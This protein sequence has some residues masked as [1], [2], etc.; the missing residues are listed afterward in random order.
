VKFTTSILIL[1]YIFFALPAKSQENW[2]LRKDK[3]G[4]KVYSRATTN[5]KFDELKVE[6]EVDGTISQL[7]AL[8][9]D[10]NTQYE[11]AYKTKK[12][13]L[14]KKVNDA[15]V[16]FYTEIECP[17]PYDNRDMVV[18]MTMQQNPANKVL[19]VQ[20]KNVD[21]YLPLKKGIV[22]LKYS[23]AV[24]TV[25]PVSKQ[26]IKIVYRIQLDLGENIPAWLT[27]MFAVDGPYD[28]FSNLKKKIKLPKYAQAKY[29]FIVD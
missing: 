13:E 12:S 18:H 20:A 23:S 6:C 16:F 26:R 1:V 2:K 28:T 3:N 21:N 29:A 10:V 8:L 27:N 25:T 4:I 17:W 14:L 5:Y 9:F 11:W 22:R 24:W 19:S 7:A 15:D